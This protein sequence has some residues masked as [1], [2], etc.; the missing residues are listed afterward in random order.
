M[1]GRNYGSDLIDLTPH[2]VLEG[3]LDRDLLR[4]VGDMKPHNAEWRRKTDLKL[5]SGWKNTFSHE[6]SEDRIGSRG[7]RGIA[8]IAEPNRA[9]IAPRTHAKRS[10]FHVRPAPIHIRTIRHKI[11]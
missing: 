11:L 10:D 9:G 3:W 6:F 4:D 8:E 2:R 1:F 5:A 7:F